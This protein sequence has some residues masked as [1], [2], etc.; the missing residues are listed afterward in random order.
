MIRPLPEIRNGNKCTLTTQNQLTKFCTAYLLL[1]TSITIV[2]III[3]KLFIH[4]F[5]SPAELLSDQSSNISEE[6]MKEIARI[7]KIKQVKTSVYHPQSNGSLD[8]R[9]MY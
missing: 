7:F 5:D 2:D 8:A 3:N 4:T 9:I 6:I 1:D